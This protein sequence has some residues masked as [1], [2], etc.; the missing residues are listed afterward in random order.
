M[1][2]LTSRYPKSLLV[3]TFILHIEKPWYKKVSLFS[4][5]QIAGIK[6]SQNQIQVIWNQVQFL[7]I[8]AW[9]Q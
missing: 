7:S 8:S 1:F 5:D 3:S 9:Y 2:V 4:K 6:Q